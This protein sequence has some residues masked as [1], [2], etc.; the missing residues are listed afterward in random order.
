MSFEKPKGPVHTWVLDLG[1]V[2]ESARVSLNGKELGVLI[3]APYRIRIQNDLLKD[4]NTLEVAVSNLMTN[5]IIDLDQKKVNWKK[6]YNTNMPARRRE[7]AGPDGQFDA[8]KWT[9][10]ESGLMGPVRLIPG[11]GVQALACLCECWPLA[12]CLSVRAL[13]RLSVEPFS[14]LSSNDKM[15]SSQITNEHEYHKWKMKNRS[16]NLPARVSQAPRCGS[17]LDRCGDKCRGS[18]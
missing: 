11:D 10:R 17:G 14:A 8:S 7:N 9:P 18:A 1:R 15:T 13:V 3:G 5:R 12:E 2:A 4:Q 16:P 6:F